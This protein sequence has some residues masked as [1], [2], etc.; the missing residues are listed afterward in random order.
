MTETKKKDYTFLT[1]E[2]WE[3]IK[4]LNIS[5]YILHS[6]EEIMKK[7]PYLNEKKRKINNLSDFIMDSLTRRSE[8]YYKYG[9]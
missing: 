8:L 1:K 9:I 7:E 2:D 3:L 5:D 6:Y 4:K